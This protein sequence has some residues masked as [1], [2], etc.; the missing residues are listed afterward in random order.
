M[1]IIQI[2]STC[3]NVG[4]EQFTLKRLLIST[5]IIAVG[6]VPWALSSSL[7][8]STALQGAPVIGAG[9]GYLF[10]QTGVGAA[11]GLLIAVT[12]GAYTIPNLEMPVPN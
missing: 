3:Y 7:D 8:R 1:G 11:I 12:F 10:R 6:C 9:I 4:M 5:A 2:V